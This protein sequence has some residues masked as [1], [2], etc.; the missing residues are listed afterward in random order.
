MQYF[1]RLEAVTVGENALVTECLEDGI[2]GIGNKICYPCMQQGKGW[3]AFA[4][5]TTFHSF[6]RYGMRLAHEFYDIF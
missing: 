6:R 4:L 2:N 5:L 3:E 1:L